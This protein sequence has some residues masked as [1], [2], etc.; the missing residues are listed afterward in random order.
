MS[1]PFICELIAANK[2][3]RDA[4]RGIY[5]CPYHCFDL[6]LAY[7]L[8]HANNGYS[9]LCDNLRKLGKA[10]KNSSMSITKFQTKLRG[11]HAV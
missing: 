7:S 1:H 10:F 8:A 9:R 3:K 11:R 4:A 6:I 5:N 2:G